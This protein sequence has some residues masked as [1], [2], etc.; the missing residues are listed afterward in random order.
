MIEDAV[1]IVVVT[2][3][4]TD[5]PVRARSGTRL[6]GHILWSRTK[7]GREHTLPAWM[8]AIDRIG[9]GRAAGP[10]ALLATAQTLRSSPD[11]HC[12]AL[13]RM[14]ALRWRERL[15]ESGEEN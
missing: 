13:P 15:P 6:R 8:R 12:G 10:A 14:S 4:A 7:T 11:R 2:V 3:P 5:E 1:G 9:P